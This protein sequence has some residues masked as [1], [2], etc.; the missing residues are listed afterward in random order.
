MGEDVRDVVRLYLKV[1]KKIATRVQ[2][3]RPVLEDAL[4][5]AAKAF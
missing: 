4:A 1:V 2:Q 3:E 5:W